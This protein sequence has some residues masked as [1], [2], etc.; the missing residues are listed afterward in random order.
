MDDLLLIKEIARKNR[1]AFVSFY[2]QYKSSVFQWALS[3]SLSKEDAEEITQDVFM[4]VLEGAASFRGESKVSTWLYRLTLNRAADLFR[5]HRAQKR[6]GWLNALR[7]SG[8]LMPE[9]PILENPQW[10]L[11]QI[12]LA[13]TL[14][15]AIGQLPRKQREAFVMAYIEQIPQIEIAGILGLKLKA[16]ESTLQRAKKNLRL[17]LKPYAP[18]NNTPSKGLT[19]KFDSN[20]QWNP[21]IQ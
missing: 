11:E 6:M 7:F 18:K 13:Q 5:A 17:N 4:E 15:H 12:E 1:E 21:E 9:I 8:Q 14:Y 2:E 16:L 10:N 19:T 20:N 3:H